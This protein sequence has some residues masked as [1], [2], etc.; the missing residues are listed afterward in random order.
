MIYHTQILRCYLIACSWED[1][2]SQIL[3]E[4]L[5]IFLTINPFSLLKLYLSN[6]LFSWCFLFEYYE[7]V[8]PELYIAGKCWK[9]KKQMPVNA[10]TSSN[11]TVITVIKY[12]FKKSLRYSSSRMNSSFDNDNFWIL[13][14]LLIQPQL[15][16][17]IFL[18]HNEN[19]T[20]LLL[21][22]SRRWTTV[23]I[24]N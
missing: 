8:N 11:L 15:L 14:Y 21:T 2:P 4:T 6:D 19:T 23:I 16:Y 3:C 20:W 24:N 13:I 10:L 22:V 7:G 5:L 9:T 17:Q 18:T 12:G 1:S